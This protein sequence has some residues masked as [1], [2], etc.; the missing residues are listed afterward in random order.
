MQGYYGNNGPWRPKI[1]KS[2]RLDVLQQYS[3]C[4]SLPRVK[5]AAGKLNFEDWRE[6]VAPAGL[7]LNARRQAERDA[8]PGDLGI[9]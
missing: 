4:D 6:Q 7:S 1:F 5:N 9:L 8:R 3:R 2:R